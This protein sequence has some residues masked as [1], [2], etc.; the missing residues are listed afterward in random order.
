MC[1]TSLCKGNLLITSKLCS[2]ASLKPYLKYV[3]IFLI[4][5]KTYAYLCHCNVSRKVTLNL[6]WN[7]LPRIL[8][9]TNFFLTIC[10]QE[11]SCKLVFMLSNIL[12]GYKAELIERPTFTVFSLYFL[13][14]LVWSTKEVTN[15]AQ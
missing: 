10:F 2:C 3:F 11:T 5:E 9:R 6:S 1:G 15:W 14:S 12:L 7:L 13:C 4:L 8:F